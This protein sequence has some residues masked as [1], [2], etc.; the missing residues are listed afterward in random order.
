M[1]VREILRVKGGTLYTVTPQQ[2]L[3]FAV[4]TMSARPGVNLVEGAPVGEMGLLRPV[5]TAKGVVNGYQ[6]EPRE[7]PGVSAGHFPVD[8][9][10]VMPGRDLLPLR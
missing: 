2:S 10:V 1:Q 4:E 5:P 9:A 3:A 8:R 6:F 7:L